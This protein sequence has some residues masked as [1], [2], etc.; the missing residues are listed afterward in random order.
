MAKQR[1]LKN[2]PIREG[3]I[4]IQFEPAVPMERLQAFV[5]RVKGG[6]SQTAVLWQAALGFELSQNKVAALP[7]G[8]PSASVGFRLAEPT[9]VLMA[10]MNGFTYSRLAPYQDWDELRKAG[11]L[12]WEQFHEIVRPEVVSRMAVRYINVLPLP[13]GNDDFSEFLNAAPQVPGVLPQ[14]LASFLQRVVIVDEV[15]KRQAI[16]TQAM[17]EGQPIDGR[18][19]FFLD[20]DVFRPCR[21]PGNDDALWSG[22]DDLRQFKNDIF[23]EFI[24]EK[25]AEL[26]G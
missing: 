19:H 3:L 9:H 23:F 14:S 16:V 22:L 12:L 10:R 21:L 8:K 18:T 11:K 13:I 1:Y 25:T 7:E 2:A 24:T 4:D 15:G 5:E 6:F 20:I 17:E 26:F